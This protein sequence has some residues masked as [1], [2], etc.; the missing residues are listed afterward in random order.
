MIFG[1]K[2]SETGGG[3]VK[4]TALVVEAAAP[5]V[6][7]EWGGN[8]GIVQVLVD[9]GS[10]PI[11]VARRFKL[12]KSRWLVA[13]MEVPVEIDPNKLDHFKVDWDAVPDIEDRVA[14]NDPTL[15]D[16]A[17]ARQ[18]VAGAL[19]SAGLPVTGRAAAPPAQLEEAMEKAA[20][21]PAP[22]GKVRGVALVVTIRG[23]V[24]PQHKRQT[25]IRGKSPAVLAVQIPGKPPY[26][27]YAG[28]FKVPRGRWDV[29]GNGYPVLVSTTDQNA[30]EVI[31]DEVPSLESQIGDRIAQKMQAA[32]A[33]LQ[34][35][36]AM[37]Q[38][39]T[40]AATGASVEAL[41]P[42]RDTMIANAKLALQM[43]KDPAQREMLM[44]QYKAAG[45]PVDEGDQAP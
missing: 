1:R 39:G 34:A 14:A 36:A 4:A 38:Q 31:W 20:R 9:A 26:A 27:V 10:G 33:G 2:D 21:E 44:Q 45:I 11:S 16:P 43:V 22:P 40:P 24:D 15:A 19:E 41:G 35:Q 28:R 32:Q 8:P 17:G 5:A 12:T 18:K 42:M 29:A 6:D 25:A 37:P 30:V 23:H 7:G 13:G 3:A